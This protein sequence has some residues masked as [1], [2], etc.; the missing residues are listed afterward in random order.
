MKRRSRKSLERDAALLKEAVPVMRAALDQLVAYETSQRA[1]EAEL[2]RA[3]ASETELRVSILRA[4]GL[5]GDVH[6]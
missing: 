5:S 1:L 6:E 3:E 2:E 4:M